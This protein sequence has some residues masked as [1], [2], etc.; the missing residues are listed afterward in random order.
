MVDESTL[1][2][3]TETTRDQPVPG[4]Q[5]GYEL[6]PARRTSRARAQRDKTR[7]FR[8]ARPR[9][10]DSMSRRIRDVLAAVV[11]LLPAVLIGCSQLWWQEDLPIEIG[12]HWSTPGP[13]DGATPTDQFFT[14]TLI[15][16]VASGCIGAAAALA[17]RVP[18]LG[19]RITLLAAGGVAGIAGAQWLVSAGLT[20]QAG[21]PYGSTLGAWILVQFAAFGY[22]VIPMLIAPAP[23][24]DSPR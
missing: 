1:A 19:T 5:T 20:L 22:G 6:R 7:R 4:A 3:L 21:D 15:I 23:R 13:A 2:S 10:T 9:P 18:P 8:K 14:T 16:A 17:R 24:W 11:V 12:T